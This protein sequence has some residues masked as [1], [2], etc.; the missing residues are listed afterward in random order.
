M[1]SFVPFVLGFY[2]NFKIFFNV[3][4][5]FGSVENQCSLDRAANFRPRLPFIVCLE[6]DDQV[7]ELVYI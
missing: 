3:L 4:Y 7:Y 5:E 2:L 6:F 1:Q